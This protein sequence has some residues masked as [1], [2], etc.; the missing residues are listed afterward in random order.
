[1]A[2]P[3]QTA[4]PLKPLLAQSLSAG[5]GAAAGV[6]L[7]SF[8]AN[9]S[10]L[11]VPL[12]MLQVFT[13]VL[14]SRSESTLLMLTLLMAFLLFFFSLLDVLRQWVMSR[15]SNRM[16]AAF[17]PRL[18]DAIF[19]S[20]VSIPGGAQGQVFRDL[21]TVRQFIAGPA[22]LAFFD[23]PWVPLFLLVLFLFHPLIGTIAI[24]GGL[25]IFGLALLNALI[26]RKNYKDISD[27]RVGAN[28]FA[29]A[30]LRN[31]EVIKAM[32]MLESIRRIWQD[33]HNDLLRTQTRTG[34]HTAVITGLAKFIRLLLQI[35]VMGAG[36]YLVLEGEFVPGEMIAAA[37]IMGRA[38]QPVEQAVGQWRTFGMARAAWGRLKDLLEQTPE[39]KA[40]M[41]LPEPAGRLQAE[42]IFA[43]PPGQQE[44]LL[45]NLNF[46]LEPGESLGIFG[47]SGAGKSTLARLLVG[48]W[49]VR[50][51][52]VR[53]D[54]MDVF[55]WDSEQ[56][57]KHIGYL[58]QDVELFDGTVSENI[59]RFQEA[60]SDQVV[61]A[62][63][64]AGAHQMILRL[65]KGY[66]TPIGRGGAALSG[67]QRQ[68]VGLARAFFGDP[69]LVVLDEPNANL[70]SEGEQA[71]TR[72]LAAL[73]QKGITAIV[74]AHRPN[75]LNEMDKLMFLR[76]GS[77]KQFG[78]RQEVMQAFTGPAAVP[79]QTSP[80]VQG[81]EMGAS[82]E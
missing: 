68:R 42:T 52:A 26:T 4:Q 73:K 24:V 51:G 3:K 48:V 17:N 63:K 70:D 39:R 20:S 53:L 43:A 12:Y 54:G 82:S 44:A 77:I 55:E 40:G 47:P 28:E 38:L 65:P 50:G 13:R 60:G 61:A 76:D 78:P 62:A 27:K 66:D 46:A 25:V 21:D 15:V 34:Q 18:F 14:S 69:A 30:S 59:A 33:K 6:L 41:A 1:M 11:V 10:T 58:P 2:Q 80:A 29:D 37:I 71:L 36:V 81:G 8:F 32:G 57:G 45:K 64:M 23:V 16:D 22:L 35:L 56:L 5:K 74:I 72:A 7:F 31:A 79:A 19:E 9:L 49:P 75:V 67:G